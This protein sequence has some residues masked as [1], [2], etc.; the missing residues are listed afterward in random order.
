MRKIARELQLSAPYISDLER[1]RRNWSVRMVYDYKRGILKIQQTKAAVA[2]S[3]AVSRGILTRPKRCT[4][5]R[6]NSK[7][8]G[9]LHGHHADYDKPLEVEWLC[10][11][12]HGK[13]HANETKDKLAKASCL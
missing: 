13:R 12:C 1:G 5:C 7:S 8:F 3:I 4:L 10:R 6:S 9:G 2:L 11:S